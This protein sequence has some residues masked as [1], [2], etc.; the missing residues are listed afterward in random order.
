MTKPIKKTAAAT[1]AKRT[2]P[3]PKRERKPAA[4]PSVP[5]V[6]FYDHI[7]TDA[8]RDRFKTLVGDGYESYLLTLAQLVSK[9]ETLPKCDNESILMQAAVAIS[10]KLSLEPSLGLAYITGY[11]DGKNWV[12]Q[13]Q[14]GWKGYI[15]L[16]HRTKDFLRI[17]V[18]LV[19][20]GEINYIDRLTGD[21]DWNWNQSNDDRNKLQPIGCV[22][23]FKLVPKEPGLPSF[24]KSLF[25]SVNELE[26][27]A[28]K[29]SDEYKKGKGPWA[30]EKPA[31]QKKTNVKL[32]LDRFGPKS[33]EISRAIRVDQATIED[34]DGRAIHYV[35]NDKN[36]PVDFQDLQTQQLDTL[37][38]LY[39][40]LKDIVAAEDVPYI[41][42]I[43]KKQETTS[44]RKFI[45]KLTA[46]KNTQ[47]K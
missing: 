24:E 12:A 22:A 34:Y 44:Y 13:F 23:Y 17:N 47:K 15:E 26:A 37:K 20:E 6:S 46:L 41:E 21:I 10:L 3:A 5:K 7:K 1:K 19:Y 9:S 25:M 18:E 11:F 43:I 42:R 4:V 8:V 32:L 30:T 29:Y 39:D 33:P 35:D 31:M 36:K 14:M 40:E 38:K 16:C 2:T 28:L 45:N 27:H